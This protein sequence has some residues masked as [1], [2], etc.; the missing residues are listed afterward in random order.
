LPT[1]AP[2]NNLRDAARYSR[3]D[4]HMAGLGWQ[5]LFV[6]LVVIVAPIAGV[7]FLV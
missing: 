5:E 2:A 6:V 4:S 3:E 7:L 1:A